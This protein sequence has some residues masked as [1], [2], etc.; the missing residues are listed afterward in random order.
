MYRMILVPLDGSDLAEIVLPHVEKLAKAGEQPA[1]VVLLEVVEP[2]RA[3]LAGYG[4]GMGQAAVLA[5]QAAEAEKEEAQKYLAEMEKRLKAKGLNVRS[6]LK[7]GN[8]GDE[9]LDF[10]E[11]NPVDLIAMASHGRSGISRWAYGSVASKVLRGIA[12]P[13]LVV[14]PERK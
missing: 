8:A 14:T 9:I 2:P 5:Q 11:G 7:A 10:A 1:E 13:I 3:I 6:E 12:T 4:D